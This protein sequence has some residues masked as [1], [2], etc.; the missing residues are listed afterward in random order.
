[1]MVLT[2]T[3]TVL[4]VLVLR[5]H[6]QVH[7]DDGADSDDGNGGDNNDNDSVKTADIYTNRGVNQISMQ[8][9]PSES[10]QNDRGE[11]VFQSLLLCEQSPGK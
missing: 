5:V 2:T 7:R 6:H 1:M 3:A 8:S 9:S 10:Y 11:E 4:A